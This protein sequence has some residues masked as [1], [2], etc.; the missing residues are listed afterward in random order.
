MTFAIGDPAPAFTL[1]DTEGTPTALYDGTA[2]AT[3]VVFT[4][5]HCPYA[6]AWHDRLS[7][8]TLDYAERGVRVLQV[9]PNDA[10]RY[11]RDS[12][13][14]MAERVARGEF[15]GPYLHDATQDAARRWGAQTTPDVYV[16]DASGRLAYRGAPDADQ[17]DPALAA[18]WLREALEDVLAGR[19]VARPQTPP[20]GCSIKWRS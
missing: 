3:V 18:A 1:P 13:Q 10:D 2:P 17:G 14:A 11:P 12:P 9:N 7:A 20:R 5:N 6:L 19:A 15:A 8:V 4:C 16:L